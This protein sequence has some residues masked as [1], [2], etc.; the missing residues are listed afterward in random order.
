MHWDYWKVQLL[1][2][3]IISFSSLPTASKVCT[4]ITEPEVILLGFHKAWV[5]PQVRSFKSQVV[6][7]AL[8]PEPDPS[9]GP[10]FPSEET[11]RRQVLFSKPAPP[12]SHCA[13]I[14]APWRRRMLTTSWSEPQAPHPTILPRSPQPPGWLDAWGGFMVQAVLRRCSSFPGPGSPISLAGGPSW[15]P[16]SGSVLCTSLLKQTW[17]ACIK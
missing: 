12:P 17:V 7:V 6:L 11:E 8:G 1:T 3:V 5:S 15:L 9:T 2:W 13:V 10:G 14:L 4:R 16:N